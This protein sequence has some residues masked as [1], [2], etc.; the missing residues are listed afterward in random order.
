[1]CEAAWKD[2]LDQI[3]VLAEN[4]VDVGMGDYDGRTP[5]HLAACAGNTS[6]IEYLL[7]Q[8]SVMVNAVDRFGGT[9]LEVS[10]SRGFSVA[11]LPVRLR[12][13]L[14]VPCSVVVQRGIY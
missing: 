8:A 2:E 3:R 10:L 5:L 6:V 14:V 12:H 11:S 4:G 13:H 1:M 7:K 9:P